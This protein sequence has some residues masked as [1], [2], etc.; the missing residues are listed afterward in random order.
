MA[1]NTEAKVLPVPAAPPPRPRLGRPGTGPGPSPA[2]PLRRSDAPPALAHRL[3][4]SP[5]RLLARPAGGAGDQPL[6]DRQQVGVDQRRSSRARSATTLTARSAK[7]R[8]ASASSSARPAPARPAPRATR[9]SGRAKVDAFSV[10][11][12]GQARWANRWHTVC[13]TAHPGRGW[14][15]SRSPPDQ[16]VRVH[17][18]L[19][20]L[21]PPSSVQGVRRLVLLRFAGGLDSP[22]DQPR[23][24]LPTLRSQP[25]ELGIDLA[26]APE[27]PRTNASGIP[28]SSRVAVASAGVHSTPRVLDKRPLVGGR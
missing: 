3:M 14:L 2:D 18:A 27:N 24:P 8:S 9:T 17:P 19:G 15:S 12:S 11:P 28:W 20:R 5:G 7:N 13:W 4:G 21:L 1:S 25:I 6:L 23:R 26:G 10:S 16:G 22:F